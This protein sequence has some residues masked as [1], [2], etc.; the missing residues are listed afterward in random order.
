MKR[1]TLLLATALLGVGST[2][3]HSSCR[4]QNDLN[5][6]WNTFTDASGATFAC[7]DPRSGVASLQVFV[8]GTPAILDASNRPQNVPCVPFPGQSS[9]QGITLQDFAPGTYNIEVQAYDAS[10]NLLFDDQAPVTVTS[11]CGGT[12]FNAQ[13]VAQGADMTVAFTLPTTTCHPVTGASAFPTTFIW[14]ELRDQTGA[15]FATASPTS[16]PQ[17]IPCTSSNAIAFPAAPFQ[18]Y[19]L[20][21]IQEVEFD[22]NGSIIVWSFKCAATSFQHAAVN[23]GVTVSLT[24]QATGGTVTCF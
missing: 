10:G 14:Y 7:T 23:D 2:G 16:D 22:T 1:A 15:V 18:R 6:F 8:D 21:R 17:Q 19:T 11:R 9:T 24:A 5:V 3:C 20:E 4:D 12:D 13:M